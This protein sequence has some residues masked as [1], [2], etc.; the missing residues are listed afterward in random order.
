MILRW[1][2]AVAAV[3]VSRALAI[4]WWASQDGSGPAPFEQAAALPDV[5][6]ASSTEAA[7]GRG[8]PIGDRTPAPDF[9]LQLLNGGTLRTSDL[10]GKR[11]VLNFW[12]SWC[13]SCRAEAPLLARVSAGSREQGIQFVGIAIQDTEQEARA[14]LA[15]FGIT[16]PNGIDHT[17]R[18]ATGYRVAQIPTLVLLDP[19]LR[20]A[21]RW[22]GQFTEQQLLVRPR[23]A[24]IAAT[25]GGWRR[26]IGS[27][28]R[29]RKGSM[30]PRRFSHRQHG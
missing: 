5:P 30:Q 23:A 24:Q 25:A 1:L 13:A 9:Q 27:P 7:S 15:E 10:A 18:I 22:A 4:G 3:L 16:Y 11:T 2:I 29:G 21:R 20:I 12:A 14:F 26:A 6:A 28:S 17:G 8:Q 19:Q